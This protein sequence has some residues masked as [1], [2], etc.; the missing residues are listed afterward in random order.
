MF[1]IAVA[2]TLACVSGRDEVHIEPGSRADSLVIHAFLAPDS[3]NGGAPLRELTVSRCSAGSPTTDWTIEHRS[4][5]LG[6]R[7]SDPV[8][9]RYAAHIPGWTT[10]RSAL[11][12]K[13]G[14]YL[15]MLSGGGHWASTQFWVSEG[16]TVHYLPVTD[17]ARSR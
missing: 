3:A 9:F 12:M 1:G 10:T 11:P 16:G 8:F 4:A 15:V 17:R 14:C 5:G 7:P 2:A 13:S 6:A